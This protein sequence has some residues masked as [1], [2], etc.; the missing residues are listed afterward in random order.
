MPK[1]RRR[2][3]RESA[4]SPAAASRRFRLVARSC[5]RARKA[6][7]S[8]P[9]PP[10]ESTS[11]ASKP[12]FWVIIGGVAALGLTAVIVSQTVDTSSG[13]VHLQGK[14]LP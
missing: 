14:V 10:D 12:W 8:A 2:P 7:P 9:K 5:C 4:G 11:I 3:C 13:N 6:T 1:E